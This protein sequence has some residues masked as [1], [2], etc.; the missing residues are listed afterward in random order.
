MEK[1]VYV[2]YG[3]QTGNAEFIA[4]DV[5]DRLQDLHIASQCSQLNK[6]KGVDLREAASMLVIVCSTTGNGDA[7]ENCEAFWRHVK[8]RARPADTF[9]GLPYMVLGLGDTN[10]DKFCH[11][12][13][14][15]DKRLS[16]LG[17]VRVLELHC[18]DEATGLEAVVEPWKIRALDLIVEKCGNRISANDSDVTDEISDDDSHDPNEQVFHAM[19]PAGLQTVYDICAAH[20]LLH[21][22][23][24]PP[25]ANLLPRPLK[26]TPPKR[27]AINADAM[28]TAASNEVTEYTVE[29]PYIAS[30]IGAEELCRPSVTNDKHILRIDISISG[31]HTSYKPGDSIGICCPNPP[32]AVDF[33]LSRLR[34]EGEAEHRYT[35]DTPVTLSDGVVST[36]G[37][38]LYY[39]IDLVGRMNKQTLYQLA[40]HC[41]S[42]TERNIMLWICRKDEVGKQLWKHFLEDQGIGLAELLALFPSCSPPVAVLLNAANALV[43]RSYSIC[44]SPLQSPSII[45]IV[46]CVTKYLASNVARSGLC[47][48][49]LTQL[50]APLLD[51]TTPPSSLPTVRLVFK[52]TQFFHL[53][54]SLSPPLILIGAGT[55]V[56]PLMGF[57]A[58]RSELVRDRPGEETCGMWRGYEID[59]KDDLPTEPTRLGECCCHTPGETYLFFGCRDHQDWIFKNEMSKHLEK[60]VLKRLEVALSRTSEEK[61]YVTH[62][63][64]QRGKE[65]AKHIME[66]NAYVFVCG[67]V[68]MAKSVTSTLEQILREHENLSDSDAQD[69]LNNMKSRRR[70][71]LD[72][73]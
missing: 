61:E 65:L 27:T 41:S 66:N 68:N 29:H 28:D 23:A 8:L 20:N 51:S 7:P 70:F 30:I 39:K 63:M 1:A 21:N 71:V 69:L 57:L 40:S 58:H 50:V 36:I 32:E 34:Y 2:L 72:I 53:P 17:G 64:L 59:A 6:V 14:V 19:I 46:Y 3:S 55:G 10:Y 33:V 54:A 45:S 5:H 56:S 24:D 26:S 38:I 16:E 11:M 44:S 12:G 13:K 47:T 48:T 67:G 62:K 35:L 73:W 60:G 49:Y 43:P 37:E 25:A 4:K 42:E 52:P 22:F 15:I 18:A 31:A 9:G